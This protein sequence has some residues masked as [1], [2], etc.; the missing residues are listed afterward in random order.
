[1]TRGIQARSSTM[2]FGKH[3]KL[4][5]NLPANMPAEA[6]GWG[7]GKQKF[8][9]EGLLIF[10]IK[11]NGIVFE[12]YEKIVLMLKGIRAHDPSPLIQV[13][14]SVTGSESGL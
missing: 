9:V 12:E 5:F 4:H 13:S 11:P 14:S 7:L 8:Y 2:S 3:L 6:I 1:M 10:V